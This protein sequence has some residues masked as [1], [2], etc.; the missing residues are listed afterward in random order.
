MTGFNELLNFNNEVFKS[1]AFWSGV[2]VL[3][4]LGMSFLTGMQRF[5]KKVCL[6]Y[7]QLIKYYYS[8]L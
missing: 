8:I 6:F 1:Y 4:M 3:K 7:A 2:L 5:R